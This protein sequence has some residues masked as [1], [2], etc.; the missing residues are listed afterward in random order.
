MVNYNGTL[1]KQKQ[2]GFSFENRGFHYGDSLFETLRVREGKIRFV[3]DHYFRLMASM[4]ML[5]MQIPMHFTYEYFHAQL[6]VLLE[7]LMGQEISRLKCSVFRKDGGRYKPLSNEI[8]FLIQASAEKGPKK[9]NYTIDLYKDHF[10]NSGMLSTVKSSDRLLNVLSSLYAEENDLD[11]C[12]LLNEKKHLVECS[13]ANLFLVLGNVVKTPPLSDGCIKG[14]SRK[15]I[16]EILETHPTY[17]SEEVS[18]SPF[19]LQR[20]DE[21]FLTNVIT[22]VQSVTH[23]RKKSY[24]TVVGTK[25]SAAFEALSS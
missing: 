1:L 3:E 9:I 24:A 12:V 2:G 20:A 25:L 23:F 21:V 4:R 15:K 7:A 22:G 5:R 10:V 18:I 8:E 6:S 16:L 11:N 13:N 14:V 17:S 19:D